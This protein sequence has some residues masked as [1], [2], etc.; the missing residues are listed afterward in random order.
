M[1]RSADTSGF[2]NVALAD[3]WAFMV[4]DQDHAAIEQCHRKARWLNRELPSK[5]RPRPR[6]EQS[7]IMSKR[8]APAITDL[9]ETSASRSMSQVFSTAA[10]GSARSCRT[11]WRDS[12]L[13]PRISA[14]TQFSCLPTVPS[15][16][17]L[18]CELPELLI[19]GAWLCH[20]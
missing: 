3:H 14:S 9:P 1:C 5:D 17:S 4:I 7:R 19:S 18:S 16:Y 8:L 10:P 13:W 20:R 6:G 11:A 2:G 12:A 15:R